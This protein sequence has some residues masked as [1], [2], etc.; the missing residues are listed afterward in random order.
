MANF[1]HAAAS[2]LIDLV[3]GEHKASINA[4]LPSYLVRQRWFGGKSRRVQ[5]A[6][7]SSLL[8]VGDSAF[9]IAL[10]QVEYEDGTEEM[11]QLPLGVAEGEDASNLHAA[12]PKAVLLDFGDSNGKVLFDA[13][14]DQRFQKALAAFFVSD[15]AEL[16]ASHA[17]ALQPQSLL[18]LEPRVS[19]A[20]QSNTSIFL[21][22][23]A[24]LKLFR[25]LEPGAN[26]EVEMT[27]FLTEVADFQHIPAYLGEIHS[28]TGTTLAVLQAFAPNQGDG[29]AWFEKELQRFFRE[30]SGSAPQ[31]AASSHLF[32]VDDAA[33]ASLPGAEAGLAA[34]ALL[35]TRTAEMHLALAT[36]TDDA[37]FAS[38]AVSPSSLQVEEQRIRQQVERGLDALEQNLASVP[39]Q[40][41]EKAQLL[42]NRREFLIARCQFA[43]LMHQGAYGKRIRIH[44]DYHLGQTLRTIDDFLIV[45]FEGEPAQPL[46]QRRRKQSPLKDI[47]GMLRSFSYAASSALSSCNDEHK[48]DASALTQWAEAWRDASSQQFLAAYAKHMRQHPG[49]IPEASDAEHWL[50]ALLLEKS[51]YELLYE[52][53][54]RPSWIYIPIDGMLSLTL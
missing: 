44:G 30:T 18:G 22:D 11:Y 37:A 6:M 54:N 43:S 38:D 34:A 48:A 40:F 1:S 24:I 8:P 21:A 28:P 45:D 33:A 50:A 46:A 9:A 26:P 27:R 5:A 14:V 17:A 36:Q 13:A 15:T 42:L 16:I 49:I 32:A 41:L 3:N 20:E 29:W 53:N 35:G 23:Q 31:L 10:I 47:A 51:A 25:R 52:L 19:S 12:Q 39:H 2:D 4:A 7:I